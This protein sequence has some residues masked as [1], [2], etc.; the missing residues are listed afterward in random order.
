MSKCYLI[1][2]CDDYTKLELNGRMLR[3]LFL[4]ATHKLN[5]VNSDLPDI[6]KYN[7]ILDAAEQARIQCRRKGIFGPTKFYPDTINH[8]IWTVM[9]KRDFCGYIPIR[10]PD[11]LFNGI[12]EKSPKH[13]IMTDTEYG[14]I[15]TDKPVEPLNEGEHAFLCKYCYKHWYMSVV[16]IYDANHLHDDI[17]SKLT[18]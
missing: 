8:A 17:F 6:D 9:N 3:R 15:R 5:T 11:N 12:S 7:L 16:K 10:L 4:A 2:D 1:T 14:C 13:E 18:I